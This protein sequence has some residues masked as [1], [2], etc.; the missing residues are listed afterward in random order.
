VR[1][2][3]RRRL[4]ARSRSAAISSWA[5]ASLTQAPRRRLDNAHILPALSLRRAPAQR[6]LFETLRRDSSGGLAARRRTSPP[7]VSCPSWARTRTLLIQRGRGNQP[8]SSNLLPK[9]RVRVTRCWSLLGRMLDLAGLY[10]LRCRSLPIS[11]NPGTQLQLWRCHA[12]RID[13]PPAT[14]RSKRGLPRSGAKVGSIL[15]QPGDS[16]YGILSNGSSRSRAF[17]GSPT[18]R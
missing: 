15:S 12:R 11:L 7:P 10:S 3:V 2:P 17:S 16:K 6:S 1:N 9:M 14:S 5:D 18:S 13:Y 4:S 8:D